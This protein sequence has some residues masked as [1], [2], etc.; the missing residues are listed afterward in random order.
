MEEKHCFGSLATI[1]KFTLTELCADFHVSRR[2]AT[3]GYVAITAKAAALCTTA[4]IG[5]IVASIKL[6]SKSSS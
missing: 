1:G 2:P 3:S 6:P 4:A 5:R